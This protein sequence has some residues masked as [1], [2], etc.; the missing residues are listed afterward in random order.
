MPPTRNRVGGIL[1]SGAGSD[2]PLVVRAVDRTV[3]RCELIDCGRLHAMSQPH[4]P[5]PWPA[6]KPATAKPATAGPATAK[7]ATATTATQKAATKKPGK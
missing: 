4:T 5:S 2:P 6:A 3:Y 1:P 7:P